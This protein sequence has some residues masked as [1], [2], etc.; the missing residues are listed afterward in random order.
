MLRSLFVGGLFV[1]F[2]IEVVLIVLLYGGDLRLSD[3][4]V[5]VG[6]GFF[7]IEGLAHGGSGLDG[8]R[9]GLLLEEGV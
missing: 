5:G 8:S 7:L 1:L 6:L 4:G 3:G 9:G 2:F